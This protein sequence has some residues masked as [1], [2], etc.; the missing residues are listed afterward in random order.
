MAVYREPPRCIMCGEIIATGIYEHREN[1]IG[2]T[3]VGWD[4]EEHNCPKQKEWIA[5]MQKEMEKLEFDVSE[6]G[7]T[8]LINHVRGLRNVPDSGKRN[9]LVKKV[10]VVLTGSR[11]GSSLFKTVMM[12]SNDIAFLSG[13]EEPYY[14]LSFNAYP[15]NKSD[16]FGKTIYNQQWLLDDIL[17]EVGCRPTNFKEYHQFEDE[18]VEAWKNRLPLQMPKVSQ[19]DIDRLEKT[20]REVFVES[21]KSDDRWSLDEIAKTI[22]YRMFKDS[23]RFGFYDII[24]EN[25]KYVDSVDLKLEEPPYVVPGFKLKATDQDLQEKTLLFKTPQDCYRPGLFEKLFPNAEIKYIHLMRGFAQSVN[26]LMDGW[27]YDSGFF[28]HNMKLEGIDDLKIS[29]Y[30]DNDEISVTGNHKSWWNFDLPANWRDFIG[31]PLHEV[32]YNQWEQSHLANLKTTDTLKSDQ[33]L[34]VKFENF[35]KNPKQ[36]LKRIT[37]FL[38]ISDIKIDKLPIVMA[39]NK[40]SNYRWKKREEL[41]M[42]LAPKAEPLMETLGYSMNPKTWT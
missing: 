31:A 25:T 2:D 30:S 16:A 39:T 33:Y 38:E 20:I 13:E 6:Q 42:Q 12:K 10:C 28:A 36:E 5:E 40:P 1:F 9:E 23:E 21:R 4:Y 37:E 22:I 14:F 32:C 27:I 17:N 29:G 34:R 18:Y 3:F 35:L 11:N 19:A 7:Y 24:P 41:I 26:G 15:W 8:N